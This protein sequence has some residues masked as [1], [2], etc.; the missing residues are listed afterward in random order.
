M[1]ERISLIEPKAPAYHVFSGIRLPRLGLPLIGTI[2]KKEGYQV[3]VYC[4]DIQRITAQDAQEIY[5]SDLV[6]VSITTSTAPAG[7]RMAKILRRRDIP[8]VFGGV[9]ATF[10]AEEALRYADYCIRGEGEEAMVELLKA[11]NGDG[12]L[13]NIKGLSYKLEGE[14]YHNE[15]RGFIEDLDTLPIPDLTLIKGYKKIKIAPIATSRG[16]P[17]DCKFCSVTKM[18]GRKYRFRSIENTLAE[19]RK[20]RDKFIFFYDDHF[21]ANKRQTKELLTRMLAE[22]LT[23]MWS[24]QVR[25]DVVKDKEL[26]DLMQKTN[27]VVLYIGF[28]SVNPKAL[29]AFRK[30]QTVDEMRECIAELHRHNIAVHG[31][32]IFGSDEDDLETLMSTVH[33][34]KENKIESVQFVMLIPLPGTET[35]F[36]LDR[37][38]RIFTKEWNLY[39]GQHIVF[40]P[41]KLTPFELQRNTFRALGSF[42]SGWEIFKQFWTFDILKISTRVI[43]WLLVKKWLWRNRRV[44]AALKEEQIHEF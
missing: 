5:K 21:T 43:G 38:G 26:L 13:E 22:G 1:I 34:V 2:L 44:V 31:M 25:T 17:F 30:Q 14:I 32:F 41:A 35:Y 9:H 18:F 12:S 19:I 3:S 11:L 36:Q 40:E 42:Y 16:C 33:F 37:E 8:V 28:E 20:N 4:Q 10:M 6:G 15:G 7:Y 39:D 24:A 23:P 27:C 29:A